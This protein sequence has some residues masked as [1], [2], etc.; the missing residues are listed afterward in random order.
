[1]KVGILSSAH[2]HAGA[3]VMALKR[4]GNVEI[5]GIADEDENRGKEFAKAHNIEYFKD[6][7]EF[8]KMDM[9]AVIICSENVKH[10]EMA[11]EAAKHGKHVIVEKPIATTI[12]DAEKMIN[13]CDENNVK[14]MVTFPIRYSPAVLRAKGIIDSGK[15]GEVIAINAT[16]RGSMPGGWFIDKELSGGGCIIDHTVH[17]MDIINMIL[18]TKVKEVYAKKAT[19]IHDIPVEDTGILSIELES[20]VYITLDTSWSR[21]VSY[22]TWGDVTMEIVGTK[23]AISVDAYAQ[24]SKLYSNKNNKS[25]NVYWGDNPDYLMMRDFID[26]IEKDK[27]SPV[28][29]EDGLF[30]LNVAFMAYKS[31]EENKVVSNVTA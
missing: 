13:V 16:N 20:G 25:L 23:G 1:M 27:P 2:M 15:I 26:C 17:V 31:A 21:P 12:A 5:V 19:L 14:L 30:A 29:G 28:T 3:Y 8:L 9:D 10:C 11:V 4:L 7:H 24:S 22:P 6:Y 18:N